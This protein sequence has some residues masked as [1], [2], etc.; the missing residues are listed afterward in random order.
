MESWQTRQ[1][2]KQAL[3][4]YVQ[5]PAAMFLK[6]AAFQIE[7]DFAVCST[8][9]N[10]AQPEAAESK[11][12]SSL[13]NQIKDKKHRVVGMSLPSSKGLVVFRA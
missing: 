2:Q 10:L 7:P 1:E 9:G 4:D 6:F 12:R 13:F 3:F 11:V 8:A 5:P